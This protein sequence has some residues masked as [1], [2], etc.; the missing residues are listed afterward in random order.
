MV[1]IV[2]RT[3]APA[4]NPHMVLSEDDLLVV[5]ARDD[6]TVTVALF[7]DTSVRVVLTLDEFSNL[8]ED[9]DEDTEGNY[10][11]LDDG[12]DEYGDAYGHSDSEEQWDDGDDWNDWDHSSE[13]IG[14]ADP[15]GRSALRRAT[16]NNPRNQPCPSCGTPNRLTPADVSLGYQCDTCADAAERGGW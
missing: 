11:F 2:T 14:F 10:D 12:D 8:E 1:Y 16:P 7:E 4:S 15:G 3:F 5:F 6:S 13:D 9:D